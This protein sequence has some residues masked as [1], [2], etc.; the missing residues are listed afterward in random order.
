[1]ISNVEKK[2]TTTPATLI[3]NLG[4]FDNRQKNSQK[5]IQILNASVIDY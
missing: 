5:D 3:Y 1:M 2:K 4:H